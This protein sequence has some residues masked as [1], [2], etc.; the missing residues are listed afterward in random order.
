[1][2]EICLVLS[3]TP[4]EGNKDHFFLVLSGVQIIDKQ[5]VVGFILC[6]PRK[7]NMGMFTGIEPIPA[8]QNI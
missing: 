3:R 1:M 8:M 7:K 2:T 6:S 5:E 4:G